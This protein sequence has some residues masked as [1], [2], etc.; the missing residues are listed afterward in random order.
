MESLLN[1]FGWL[2]SILTAAGNGF[3]VF[4]VIKNRRL[5]SSS[6]WFVL[7][8]AVAD[9]GVGITVYPAGYFCHNSGPCNSRV[10]V[11]L[12]WFLLHSSVTNLCALTW[13]RYIAIVHPFKY[14]ASMT[15]RH[16]GRVILIAWLTALGISLSLLAGIYVTES[17]TIQKIIRVISVSAF[18]MISCALL[19]YAIVRI[20]MVVR[21]R[22]HRKPS[23][24]PQVQFN[25]LC[26]KKKTFHPRVRHTTAWFTIVLVTFFLGCYLA[27]TYLVLRFT[28]S[29][30]N[31][32]NE[33][34]GHVVI[35]LL[36]VNSAVNPLVYA[37]LKSDIKRE[38]SK[39]ICRGNNH[40]ERLSSVWFVKG[41][42]I[43]T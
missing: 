3:V 21:A 18:D 2:L 28:F 10:Y 6:N 20:L 35:F 16:P 29:C 38:L 5:H 30:Q 8:L 37:F 14:I 42:A 1:I 11:A 26:S 25:Q 13:D 24:K 4:L 41:L 36:V 27:V 43:S 19:F 7:S 12:F 34:S 15:A 40:R 31:E 22:S 17:K 33:A 23:A 39:L 32:S 9:F